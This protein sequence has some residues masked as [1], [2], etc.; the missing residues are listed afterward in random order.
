LLLLRFAGAFLLRLAERTFNGWLLKAPPRKERLWGRRPA[1]RVF[2]EQP[3]PQSI[4]IGLGGVAHP[5]HHPAHYLVRDNF[6]PGVLQ[7]PS[8]QAA[9]E[10]PNVRLRQ[11]PVRA[12]DPVAE[13]RDAVANGE[14]D[15]LPGVQP[16]PQ[17]GQDLG[18]L[19]AHLRRNALSSAKTRKSS[20]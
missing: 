9:A 10:A 7:L 11:E 16:Q 4:G 1:E 2:L 18:R 6:V 15:V 14:D 3:L 12:E 20:Q 5:A 17:A 8:A 13:E 19:A